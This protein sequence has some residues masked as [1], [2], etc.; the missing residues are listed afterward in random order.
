M[1]GVDKRFLLSLGRDMYK[2]VNITPT[3]NKRRTIICHQVLE[4]HFEHISPS[5][6]QPSSHVPQTKP[7]YP[8]THLLSTHA[9]GGMQVQMLSSFPG[10]LQKPS[11][12]A[13]N[14]SPPAHSLLRGHSMQSSSKWVLLGWV[15]RYAPRSQ[16]QSVIWEAPKVK[17]A[18]AWAGQER[19][20]GSC[21][22]IGWYWL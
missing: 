20:V 7:L 12:G 2:I 22:L 8:S 1:L 11:T 3:T 6:E 5:L 14:S 21:L 18:T 19:Q 15:Y 10:S 4:G 17:F 16:I 9:S 13:G